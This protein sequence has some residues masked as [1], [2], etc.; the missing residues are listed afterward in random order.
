MPA[1]KIVPSKRD[2]SIIIHILKQKSRGFLKN[3][4]KKFALRKRCDKKG[5][6]R[7]RDRIPPTYEL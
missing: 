6:G 4:L 7:N 3:L 2:N 5:K 1:Y